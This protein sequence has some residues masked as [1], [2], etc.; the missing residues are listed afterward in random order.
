MMKLKDTF[1]FKSVKDICG[2]KPCEFVK[3]AIKTGV[4]VAVSYSVAFVIVKG[5]KLVK[6]NLR[7]EYTPDNEFDDEF[8]QATDIIK[9]AVEKGSEEAVKSQGLSDV[10]KDLSKED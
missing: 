6:D 9:R 4:F 2:M 7:I 1:L 5:C 3:T 8:E 10:A